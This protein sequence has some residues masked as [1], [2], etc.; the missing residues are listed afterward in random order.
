MSNVKFEKKIIVLQALNGCF[1]AVDNSSGGYPYQVDD[2]LMAHH[3]KDLDD[4]K[5]YVEHFPEHVVLELI[6]VVTSTKV[7][8]GLNELVERTINKEFQ[9]RNVSE[10]YK[11]FK[12]RISLE[13]V[14]VIGSI[15]DKLKIVYSREGLVDFILMIGFEDG[16]QFLAKLIE[17]TKTIKTG[18]V[19]S[20]I[21][22][23][24]MTEV[25]TK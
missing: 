23:L 16:P 9:Y 1:I 12:N 7:L 6:L 15:F 17:I 24:V 14:D 3:F 5:R 4:A 19:Y 21:G 25:K 18:A 13:L 10:L 20:G 22:N 2:L 8:L 11:Q